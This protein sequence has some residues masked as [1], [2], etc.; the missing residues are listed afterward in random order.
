MKAAKTRGEDAA[1]EV[2]KSV[3]NVRDEDLMCE[4]VSV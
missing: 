2:L 3:L 1:K 4:I